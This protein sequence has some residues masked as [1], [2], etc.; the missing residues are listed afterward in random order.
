MQISGSDGFY[1]AR[2]DEVVEQDDQG[3]DL[4][5]RR[6]ENGIDWVPVEDLPAE[7]F[8]QTPPGLDAVQGAS[9]HRVRTGWVWAATLFEDGLHTP[10][11]WTSPDGTTWEPIDTSQLPGSFG[12]SGGAAGWS[13][14]GWS[15][16]ESTLFAKYKK[17]T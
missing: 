2:L 8:L 15:S 10:L 13:A 5:S 4:L 3:P 12:F 16:F 14:S 6:S 17:L 11:I 1:W 9:F 7:G